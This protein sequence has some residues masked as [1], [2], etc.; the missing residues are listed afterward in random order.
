MASKAA[1]MSEHIME[2]QDEFIMRKP[3]EE[4]IKSEN[5]KQMALD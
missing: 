2:S 5:D 4:E 1:K 3:E